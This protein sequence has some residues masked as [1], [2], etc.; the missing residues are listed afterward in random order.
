MSKQ[1]SVIAELIAKSDKFKQGMK[2]AQQATKSF[3]GDFKSGLKDSQTQLNKLGDSARKTF[4]SIKTSAKVAG[5]SMV[6]MFGA[7]TVAGAKFNA[8]MEQSIT[9]YEILLGSMEKA[10]KMVKDLQQFA[11]NSPFEFQG[12]D[13]SAKLLLAMGFQGEQIIP[14]MHSVGNAVSAAGGNTET[15]EGISLAL[16]QILTKGKLS[17]EEMTQ[18]AERGIPAWSIL[19]E[20][21][22]LTTQEVMKLGEQGKLFA[23]DVLPMLIEGLDDKFAGAMDKQSANF[24]GMLNNLKETMLMTLGDFTLPFF[25]VLKD[26]LTSLN[27]KIQ[28]LKNNGTMK[29]WADDIGSSLVKAYNIAKTVG[30]GIGNVAIWIKDHWSILSPIVAGFV[31]SLVSL[32][33]IATITLLW[34]GYRKA[35]EFATLA[36]HGLNIAMRANYIGMIITAIGLLVTAIVGLYNMWKNNWGGIQEKTQAVGKVITTTLSSAATNVELAFIRMQSGVLRVIQNI[37]NALAPLYGAIGKVIPSVGNTFNGVMDAVNSKAEQLVGKT[38]EL[39]QAQK[40]ATQAMLGARYDLKA[41]M[42]KGWTTPKQL[43]ITDNWQVADTAKELGRTLKDAT[44][45]ALDFGKAVGAIGDQ[46]GKVKSGMS[47]AKNTIS[48][49]EFEMKRLRYMLDMDLY[50]DDQ[51]LGELN[52]IKKL[53]STVDEV[54]Q[55]NV[56][57]HNLEKEMGRK[58]FEDSKKWIDERKFYNELSLKQELE[59]WERVINRQKFKSE[60]FLEAQREIYRIKKEIEKDMF[61]HSMK[62]IETEKYFKRLS[63]EE[64]I[65]AYQRVLNRHKENK[66]YRIQLEK[67]IFRVQEEI[68]DKAEKAEKQRQDELKKFADQVVDIY[69]DVYKKQKD[70]ALDAIKEEESALERSHKKKM[71]MHD[72]ELSSYEEIIKAK[73]RSIDDDSN[74]EEFN[75]RLSKAQKEAQDIQNQLNVAKLDDSIENR[76]RIEDFEKQHK[77]KLEQIE[78]MQ[79]NRSK[80]L[81]KKS[82]QDQL[83]SYKKDTES[84]KKSEIDKYNAEKESLDNRKKEQE[85]YW[86]NIINDERKFTEIRRQVLDGNLTAIESD[87][88]QFKTFLNGNMKDIG[89]SISQNLIDKMAQAKQAIE[90]VNSSI[91]SSKGSSSSSGSSSGSGNSNGSGGTKTPIGTIKEGSGLGQFKIVNDRATA[92]IGQLV[93][94]LGGSYGDVKWDDKTKSVTYKGKTFKQTASV[95]GR[96]YVNVADFMSSFGRTAEWDD[97]KRE[98]KIFHDGGWVGNEWLGKGME[99]FRK[100]FNLRD[101][102]QFSILQSGEFVLSRSMISSLKNSVAKLNSSDMAKTTNNSSNSLNFNPIFNLTVNGDEQDA[103]KLTKI[104]TDELLRQMKPYGFIR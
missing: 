9:S 28:E 26:D 85:R 8:Q 43:K 23:N 19:A 47:S 25:N 12:L 69:K 15:L 60:E 93:G 78:E 22:G 87:F 10:N 82:L 102:E 33:V 40:S 51:H 86:D 79:A 5:A 2:D 68:R 83:D 95:D 80:D 75:K 4:D 62:W 39:E 99:S 88:A 58:R 52:R 53:A 90:N 3:M 1:Y 103:K 76:A 70:V 27:S 96:A 14:V 91:G 13:K 45:T 49:F 77:E 21:M 92:W 64:E 98:V 35:V 73:L 55:I 61:D 44:P 67:E 37:G 6:A 74:E 54:R 11:A 84:K 97:A 18:L 7:S 32:K 81:R 65:A 48:D 17:A 101:D 41:E 66:E 31:A 100:L 42:D 29:Q 57:I 94:I 30:T 20:K 104:V 89:E 34:Q 46:A 36:Q 24:L 72:E 16:G 56:E 71:D 38:K 63:A 50:N 59:A